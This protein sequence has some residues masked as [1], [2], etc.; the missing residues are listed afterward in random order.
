VITIAFVLLYWLANHF[1]FRSA[2]GTA[3][4]PGGLV[5][6]RAI[7]GASLVGLSM[8]ATLFLASVLAVFLT[9]ASVRGDAEIGLLQPL[10]VRPVGRPLILIGRW[11]GANVVCMGYGLFLYTASVVVTGS[12]GG[13]WPA[14]PA[15]PAAYLAGAIVVVTTISVLGS[16]FLTT[17]TNGIAVLMVYGAGLLAGLLGQ[18]GHAI[19]SPSLTRTA[20][21]ATWIL[22]FEA[23][24]QGGLHALTADTTGVTRFIVQLGPLGGAEPAGDL[25]APYALVYVTIVGGLSLYAF[26]RRDL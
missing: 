16:V 24:Y 18:I 13:W 14:Q 15:P 19:A 17:I 8:F 5:D 10:A 9:F 6:E 4:G 26:T 23:L 11:V 7:V 2:R 3:T 21:I 1:A 20:T 22:P 25:L 12:T